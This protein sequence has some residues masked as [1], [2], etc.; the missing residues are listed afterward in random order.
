MMSIAYAGSLVDHALQSM[1]ALVQHGYWFVT[2]HVYCR[3]D[4]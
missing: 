1:A 2:R 3:T 4:Y